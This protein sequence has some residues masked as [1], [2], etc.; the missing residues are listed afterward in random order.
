[1]SIAEIKPSFI[2]ASGS[3]RRKELL[4]AAGFSFEIAKVDVD[5]T[6][7]S[8]LQPLEVVDELARKK[9]EACQELLNDNLVLTA[10][11][12]VFK[13]NDILGKP[14]DRNDAVRMLRLLSAS[15]HNVTTSVCL[16]YED[17]VHQ[18]NVTTVVGFNELDDKMIDYYLDNYE[19]YD[20]AGSYG[21]QE[22]LGQVAIARIE[23]SYTN[24]VGLPVAETYEAILDVY[25]RWNI[26]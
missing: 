18:F 12:L 25:K 22:W 3:P 20:K 8:E 7:N 23:G 9:L 26:S 2:L 21:I 15:E 5:E 13:G 16:G 6:I 1:M 4:E 14:L 17:K 19:P 10:D 11:T 24:V